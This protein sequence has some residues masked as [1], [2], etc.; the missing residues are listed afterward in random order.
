M[1]PSLSEIYDSFAETYEASRGLFDMT[2]VLADFRSRLPPA[3]GRMLDLGCGAGEPFP[4]FFLDLGWDVVGVDFSRKM[5]DLAA[6]FVPRMRTLHADMSQVLFPPASFDAITCVYSFFHL[7]AALQPPMF[8]KFFRWLRPGGKTL[9]TYATRQ[10]TGQDEF[11]GEKVFM[12]QRLFYSH[13]TPDKLDA[14]L[15]LA[16]LLPES[17]TLRNVGGES[18]LWVV[19][20]RP[21]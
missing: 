14:Q 10:Y 2:D 9:F 16:G 6:R 15:R 21:A 1:P 11:E 3:P 20:S 19:A 13:S 4:R 12:G 17:K 18:F 8:A 5:L 7:P